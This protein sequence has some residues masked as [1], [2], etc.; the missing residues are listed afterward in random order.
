VEV[1]GGTVPPHDWLL[2]LQSLTSVGFR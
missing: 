1:K 2:P